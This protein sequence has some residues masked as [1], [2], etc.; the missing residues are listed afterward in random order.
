MPS[1]NVADCFDAECTLAVTGPITIPLDRARFYY[2]ELS[3]VSVTPEG[4]TYRVDYPHGGGAE[5]GMGPGG[6]SGFGFRDFPMVE[7][8]LESINDGTAVLVL[9]SAPQ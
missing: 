1:T 7:V 4:L 2:P 5:Q 8:K 3:V 9:R 6:G